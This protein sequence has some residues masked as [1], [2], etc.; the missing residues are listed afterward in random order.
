MVL[1]VPT[2]SLLSVDRTQVFAALYRRGAWGSGR[3]A[4]DPMIM[5]EAAVEIVERAPLDG[6]TGMGFAYAPMVFPFGVPPHPIDLLHQ[7]YSFGVATN[8]DPPRLPLTDPEHIARV[9]S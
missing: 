9:A 8:G 2:V 6:D 4:S 3:N 1:R 5:A 7:G